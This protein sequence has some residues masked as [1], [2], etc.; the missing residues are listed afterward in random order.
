MRHGIIAAPNDLPGLIAWGCEGTAIP[1]AHGDA[2][3]TGLQNTLAILDSCSAV[4][5][6]A[7]LCNDLVI[8]GFDD[9]FLPSRFEMYQ[10]NLNKDYVPNLAAS[11][12]YYWTSSEY[13]INRARAMILGD[14]SS[15]K[16]QVKSVGYRVRPVRS[17]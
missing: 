12:P 13:D 5:I 4:G 7:Q 1:G 3:G 9:W 15:N 14:G 2:V 11:S 10:I 17:F 6:A 16:V 8:N